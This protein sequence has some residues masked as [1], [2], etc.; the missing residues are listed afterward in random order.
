MKIV[1]TGGHGSLGR[2]LRQHLPGATYLSHAECDVSDPAS[3]RRALLTRLPDVVIHAA[4]ITDHQCRDLGLLLRTNVLGTLNVC[5]AA[6]STKVVYL[7]THY[8]YPGE[9][10]EYRETD[11][12]KPIGA[13]A[14]T[15]YAGEFIVRSTCIAPLIIRGSW[16]TPE[17]LDLWRTQGIIP[18]VW[19]NREPVDVAAEKIAKLVLRDTMGVVNIGGQRRTFRDIVPDAP[20]RSKAEVDATLDYPFPHDSSVNTDRYDALVTPAYAL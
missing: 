12:C 2:A 6:G 9:R 8:V 18:D 10:G 13:Y 17:K 16:Y 19:C 5:R 4:A 14:E 7:S 15:K 3:V 20:T 1:V 11:I